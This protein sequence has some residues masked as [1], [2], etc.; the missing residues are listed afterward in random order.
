MT[1]IDE[2]E[3]LVAEPVGVAGVPKFVTVTVR[4]AFPSEVTL[5]VELSGFV[6]TTTTRYFLPLSLILREP[7]V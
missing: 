7:V 2:A 4:V 6:L 1:L 5:A 3:P